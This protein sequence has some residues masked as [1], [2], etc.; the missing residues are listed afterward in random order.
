ELRTPLTVIRSVGEVGLREMRDAAAYRDVIGSIL[1]ETD[2]VTGLVDALLTLSRA[3][4]GALPLLPSA[5]DLAA[6]AR[7]VG[8]VFGVLAEEKRQS[9]TIAGANVDVFADRAVVRQ[10]LVNL[11]DNAVKHSPDGATIAVTV[12]REAGGAVVEVLD[13]GPGIA[14]EHLGRIFERFY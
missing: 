10:A 4:A 5:F 8:D 7:E 3:D 9:L 11:L 13:S 12:R 14:N 6:L 2:R 1:E